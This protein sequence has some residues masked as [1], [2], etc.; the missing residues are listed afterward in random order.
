VT[1]VNGHGNSYFTAQHAVALL[2][3][4]TNKIIP[5]HNWMT[6]GKWRLGDNEAASIPLRR[7]NI[8]FL[9]YGAVNQKVH[10]FLLGFDLSFAALKRKW[11]IIPTD[12]KKVDG[13]ALPLAL[14][15]VELLNSSRAFNLTGNIG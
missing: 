9:G 6:S 2:L 11:E 15:N 3:S 7:R 14:Y 10:K 8:G 5:H 12:L 13:L 1:L 4:L